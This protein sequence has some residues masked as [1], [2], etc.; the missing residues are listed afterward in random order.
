M[1][2]KFKYK[3]EKN[4]V[5]ITM[6]NDYLHIAEFYKCEYKSFF[7]KY[8][9]NNMLDI[10]MLEDDLVDTLMNVMA[11][12]CTKDEI[13]KNLYVIIHTDIIKEIKL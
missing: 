10:N 8:Y 3:T 13:K 1:K 4:Y 2:L 11:I 9:K 12:P 6:H 7:N 5:Y